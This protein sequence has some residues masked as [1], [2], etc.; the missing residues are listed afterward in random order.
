M[1]TNLP[2]YPTV[3]LILIAGIGLSGCATK[4]FVRE[5]IAV[6]NTRID[7]LDGQLR[8]VEG[9]SGQALAQAQAAAGQ[10]Q[11]NGQRIDQLTGRVDDIDQQVQQQAKQRQ[12][13][14]RG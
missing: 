2:K 12:R 14:P 8:T 10:S 3:A 11:Q 1:R 6:V 9:T 13:K 7:G 5:Q 4:G